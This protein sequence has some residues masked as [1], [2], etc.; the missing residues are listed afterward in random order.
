[1][2]F[3]RSH[4]SSSSEPECELKRI[5][6][7]KTPNKVL[8]EHNMATLPAMEEDL[9]KREEAIKTVKEN[10]PVWFSAVFDFILKDLANISGQVKQVED[11]KREITSLQKKVDELEL[12]NQTLEAQVVKLE[13]YSRKTNLFIKGIPESGPNENVADCISDFLCESLHIPNADTIKFTNVH[14][15][16]KPPHINPN[17]VKKPRDIIVRFERLADK[18]LVW[19][20]RSQLKGSPFLMLEDFCPTT[21]ERRKQLQPYF[22]AARRNPQVSKCYLN[23]DVLVIN[24]SK[25]TVDSIQKLPF[26]L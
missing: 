1:M 24:G 21:Q 26:N 12:K 20:N 5:N 13:D 10:A 4:S 3:K 23:R 17:S 9:I 19:K 11:N 22:Q 14:R 25:Y 8:I 6:L 15:L 2:S 18:E 7:Q 16:G